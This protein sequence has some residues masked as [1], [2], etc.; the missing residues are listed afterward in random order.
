MKVNVSQSKMVNIMGVFCSALVII[1]V[2]C[3][4]LI[5][6]ANGHLNDAYEHLH[7]LTLYTDAF[8]DASS[9]LTD[10]VRGYAASGDQTHYDNYWNEINID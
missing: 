4:V 1:F 9:Y 10:E 3:V 6:L 7:D 5:N 8:G 2:A